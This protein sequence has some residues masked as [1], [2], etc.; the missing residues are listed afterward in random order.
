MQT[1]PSLALSRTSITLQN[2]NV[3]AI[4]SFRGSADI[5]ARNATAD[6]I[7]ARNAISKDTIATYLIGGNAYGL[8]QRIQI[9]T[10]NT[11]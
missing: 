7:A 1:P 11:G 3:F 4:F 2:Q 6:S 8:L 9:K 5:A 10:E